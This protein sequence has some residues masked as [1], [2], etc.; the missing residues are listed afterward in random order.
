MAEQPKTAGHLS[1][2][3][4]RLG[5]QQA[6][7]NSA[8]DVTQA[9][10]EL[11]LSRIAALTEQLRAATAEPSRDAA[12]LLLADVSMVAAQVR[13]N[14]T[15]LDERL[16]RALDSARLVLLSTEDKPISGG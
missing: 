10:I 8:A 12:R 1:A 4:Q 13:G 6:H 11:L 15:V 3:L 2:V 5:L 16:G 14:T 7:G 9:H